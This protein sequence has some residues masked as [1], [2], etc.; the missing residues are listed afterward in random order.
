MKVIERH[1]ACVRMSG[2]RR[3]FYLCLPAENTNEHSR[4]AECRYNSY[5]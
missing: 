2:P 1:I 3:S 4:A 5:K